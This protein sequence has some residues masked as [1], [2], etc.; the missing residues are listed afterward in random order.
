MDEDAE[1]EGELTGQAKVLEYW[2]HAPLPEGDPSKDSAAPAELRHP[3]EEEIEFS[4]DSSVG[5]ESEVEITGASGPPSSA[6][7]RRKTRRTSSKI[8]ISKAGLTAAQRALGNPTCRGTTK[9][10]GASAP[11]DATV[12]GRLRP[13]PK[14]RKKQHRDWASCVRKRASL[15]GAKRK[16]EES[17]TEGGSS[18]AALLT[19]PRASPAKSRARLEEEKKKEGEEASNRVSPHLQDV[20]M[21]DPPHDG[22]AVHVVVD[23]R[24]VPAIEVARTEE[25]PA[26]EVKE[27]AEDE[28]GDGTISGKLVTSSKLAQGSIEALVELLEQAAQELAEGSTTSGRVAELAARV[29]ELEAQGRRLE[30]EKLK[31]E[32]ALR[33]EKCELEACNKANEELQKLREVAEAWE[34]A[35]E[36]KLHLE[37]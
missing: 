37:Q 24:E 5:S 34:A 7:Q 20:E 15:S 32:E 31:A 33:K 35:T 12:V 2:S 36:E 23:S 30:A 28:E 21:Q 25:V 14:P 1:V 10:R 17:S 8:P 22:G 16:V 4:S 29:A 18:D 11:P 13:A 26:M 3:A 6:A 9:V 27:E 19:S